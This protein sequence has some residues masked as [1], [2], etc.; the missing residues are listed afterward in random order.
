M[1]F[2]ELARDDVFRLETRRLWLRWPRRADADI[3]ARVCPTTDLARRPGVPPALAT[4]SAAADYIGTVREANETGRQ[5]ALVLAPK[6]DPAG[7]IGGVAL[8]AS[9]P[10]TLEL[11]FWL[12]AG[13]RGEG[14][15]A[16]A[17]EG[18]LAFAF[19]FTGAREIG[20]IVRSGNPQARQMLERLGFGLAGSGLEAL[21]SEGGMVP[22][23][24][25]RLERRSFVGREDARGAS[26]GPM[27]A[28]V[29]RRACCG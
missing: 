2:P 15:V 20:A 6:G 18:L 28:E 13:S 7:V 23:E 4:T 14:L 8:K 12:A 10:G 16:E 17:V 5:L 1:M 29:A 19:T 21:A 24:R 22:V 26:A 3:L 25:W 9:L 27:P 11:G